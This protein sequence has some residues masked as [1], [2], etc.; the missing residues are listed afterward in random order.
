M[1]YRRE[2]EKKIP[3]INTRTRR[4]SQQKTRQSNNI[5]Y[6]IIC[7]NIYNIYDTIIYFP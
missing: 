2:N 1:A 5:L 6:Y 7:Y 4:D 3:Q